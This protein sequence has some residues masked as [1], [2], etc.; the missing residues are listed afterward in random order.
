MNLTERIH[1]DRRR[2]ALTPIVER[3]TEPRIPEWRRR[4]LEQKDRLGYVAV[5]DLTGRAA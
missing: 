1:P 3:R 2:T 5:A 4:V